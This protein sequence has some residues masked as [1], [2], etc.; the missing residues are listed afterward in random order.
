M[1][2]NLSVVVSPYLAPSVLGVRLTARELM[3]TV[4]CLPQPLTKCGAVVRCY[5]AVLLT[6]PTA[7]H[8]T[9]NCKQI[10]RQLLTVL[11]LSAFVGRQA[12]LDE[13]DLAPYRKY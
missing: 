13:M 6:K 11:F 12:K 7:H 8:R 2:M 3:V 5:D 10:Q 9:M 1:K 4:T